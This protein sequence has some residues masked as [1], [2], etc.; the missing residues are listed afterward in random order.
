M[1]Q[2]FGEAPIGRIAKRFLQQPAHLGGQ[3]TRRHLQTMPGDFLPLIATSKRQSVK[4]RLHH[5]LRKPRGPGRGR[6]DHVFTAPNEMAQAR[7]MKRIDKTIIGLPSVMVEES[8]VVLTQYRGGLSKPTAR[9][10]RIDR[11]FSADTN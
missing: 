3:P 11:D 6:L 7:L 5:R 9:Q 4:Q 8:R 10:N 1:T 2:V